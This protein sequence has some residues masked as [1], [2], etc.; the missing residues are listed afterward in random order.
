MILIKPLMTE[1]A[2]KM[3]ELE[4]KLVF[5]VERRANKEGIKKE[6]EVAFETKIV[7]INIQIRKSNKTVMGFYE[8][9]GYTKDPVVSMGKRLVSDSP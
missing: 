9:I 3:I 2:V 6:F 7:S 5:L 1:K 4:N 8:K